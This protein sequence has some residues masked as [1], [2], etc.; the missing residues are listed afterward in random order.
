MASTVSATATVASQVH[1]TGKE[2]V[3]ET[4]EQ[5]KERAQELRSSS[6]VKF[7]AKILQPDLFKRHLEEV[8]HML[9][10]DMTESQQSLANE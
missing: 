3:K 10:S 2:E 8:R 6:K 1:L 4:L 5:R 9:H 7:R